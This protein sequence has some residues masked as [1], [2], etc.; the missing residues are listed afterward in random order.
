MLEPIF[1]KLSLKHILEFKLWRMP[2]A[3]L[4]THSVLNFLFINHECKKSYHGNLE[5]QLDDKEQ[6]MAMFSHVYML[7]WQHRYHFMISTQLFYLI[8]YILN[9]MESETLS[10][11]IMHATFYIVLYLY[12]KEYNEQI[13]CID[14]QSAYFVLFN[15]ISTPSSNTYPWTTA[16]FMFFTLIS[17]S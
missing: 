10:I 7:A 3:I 4:F 15:T 1:F 9:I 5:F 13:L 17:I 2:S 11:T 14:H 12:T 16:F 8:W 6:K